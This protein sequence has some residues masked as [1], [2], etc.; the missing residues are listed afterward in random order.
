MVRH[1]T[2]SN[3]AWKSLIT[4][5]LVIIAGVLISAVG[6]GFGAYVGVIRAVAD[7]RTEMK[8]EVLRLNAMDQ[9]LQLELDAHS[10]LPQHKTAAK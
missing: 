7:L 4:S 6:A 5:M 8:S 1:E 10:D 9:R 3:G 2:E